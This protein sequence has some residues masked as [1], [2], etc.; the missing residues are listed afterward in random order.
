MARFDEFREANERYAA[1]F[2]RGDLPTKLRR[3]LR[4]GST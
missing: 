4:L 1:S 3:L 2:D